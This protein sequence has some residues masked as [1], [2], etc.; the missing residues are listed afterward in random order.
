MIKLVNHFLD[1]LIG[2]DTRLK[3][4]DIASLMSRPKISQIL[5]GKGLTGVR[6]AKL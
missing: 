5:T 2:R 3:A 1:I 4:V 6:C